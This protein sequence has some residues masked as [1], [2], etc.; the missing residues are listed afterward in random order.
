MLCGHQYPKVLRK[1]LQELEFIAECMGVPLPF[2]PVHGEDE[3]KLLV[4]SE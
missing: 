4:H 2:L 1:L 3:A